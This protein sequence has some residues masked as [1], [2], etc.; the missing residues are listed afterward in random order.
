MPGFRNGRFCEPFIPHATIGIIHLSGST[1]K[2]YAVDHVVDGR[3][4][5]RSLRYGRP[6]PP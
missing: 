4:V 2:N 3:R 1:G 6:P 5:T